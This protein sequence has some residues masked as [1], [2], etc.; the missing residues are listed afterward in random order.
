[1]LGVGAQVAP[2]G[3]DSL[4]ENFETFSPGNPNGQGGWSYT[5]QPNDMDYV[6][7]DPTAFSTAPAS[8][9]NRSIRIS[10]AKV[11][12][13]V[14]AEHLFSAPL[15]DEVG[16]TDAISSGYSG[17]TRQKRLSFEV[18]VVSTLPS[19]QHGLQI[20]LS[21]D[22]GDGARMAL[23][24]LRDAPE[25]LAIDVW[26]YKRDVPCP[27]G[28]E[29]AG[30]FNIRTI[31]SGLDRTTVHRIGMEITANAGSA[32]DTVIIS[33]D[34][35]RL[36]GGSSWEE[37][38]RCEQAHLQGYGARSRTMDSVLFRL[39]SGAEIAGGQSRNS[40]P[41]NLGFGFLFDNFT[42]ASGP[43]LS[44]APSRFDC[45][46]P[47][48]EA[49]SSAS[50]LEMLQQAVE[51]MGHT[52]GNV[53]EL[54]GTCDMSAV[55]PSGGAPD[56][57]GITN[58]GL[59]I[60]SWSKDLT[61]RSLDPEARA[62][63]TGSGT[64]SGI[65]VAPGSDGTTVSNL[66][67]SGFAQPIVVHNATDTTIGRSV[68]PSGNQ[69]LGL[70]GNRIKGGPATVAGILGLGRIAGSSI[71]ITDGTGET[72]TIATPAG[73]YLRNL[74]VVGNYVSIDPPGPDAIGISLY[75]EQG[76]K[77][78]DASVRENAV[79]VFS[80]EF[81][82]MNMVG[83]RVWAKA[84]N[85]GPMIDGVSIDSN[86]LG[87]LE[88]VGS[89]SNEAADIHAAGRFGILANR[90]ANVTATGNGV[91]TRLSPTPGVSMP[92]GGIVY[93][94]VDGGAIDGNA[95]V[96]LTDP[97]T[98]SADMGAIGV[99]HG[100]NALMGGG[101]SGPATQNISVQSNI[102]GFVN[103]DGPV[104]AA[105]GL[106]LNGVAGIN[107]T[108]NRFKVIEERS[109]YISATLTGFGP[110]GGAPMLSPQAVHGSN[111]CGNWLNTNS[112][113]PGDRDKPPS[114]VSYVSGLGSSGNSFP[115][116]QFYPGNANC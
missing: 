14:F 60:P 18:D 42:L 83:V 97:S 114:Q 52:P 8:F 113:A 25:G 27:T 16:D 94:N 74:D 89:L 98:R 38:F 59:L 13:G 93:G 48:L 7:A 86:N 20:G 85:P 46:H 55:P 66:E 76:G 40:N 106:V 78:L 103:S 65:Y 29:G 111:L 84:G 9:G 104:G 110:S 107:A 4:G 95:I 35:T 33:V 73:Q 24:V 17:G 51:V 100:L 12:R 6:V 69:V 70:G 11:P 87:R 71:Q 5:R 21:P 80:S 19:Y 112:T 81:P 108:A 36:W 54:Q 34:G 72:H 45:S 90:A 77:I 53:L 26:N 47:Q 116:G 31:A 32:D 49:G 56:G 75:Q 68:P 37:Y 62:R 44:T 28:Q 101:G 30:S 88:L 109:V 61:L 50:S 102:V 22:R 58:A 10:N 57:T 92:G 79:G 23:M 99:I 67:L 43:A 105:K 39:M 82:S 15:A 1:M 91:R 63:F 2:A 41:A 64:Q 115:N 3:A 96:E